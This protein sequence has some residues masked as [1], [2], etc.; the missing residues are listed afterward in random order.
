MTKSISSPETWFILIKPRSLEILKNMRQ[1][2]G[3]HEHTEC[4]EHPVG[5][6]SHVLVTCARVEVKC[7]PCV[8]RYNNIPTY[9]TQLSYLR[10]C[11]WNSS[12][13]PH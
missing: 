6:P 2:V 8:L 13:C 11:L 10:N 12:R 9:I 4:K 1:F 5:T 7:S 3:L